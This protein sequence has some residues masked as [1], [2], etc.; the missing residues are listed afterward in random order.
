MKVSLTLPRG[1]QASDPKWVLGYE[2]GAAGT[3]PAMTRDEL[4]ACGW[5]TGHSGRYQ[6]SEKKAVEAWHDAVAQREG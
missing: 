3:R 2:D 1:T 4:Y 6:V 5:V